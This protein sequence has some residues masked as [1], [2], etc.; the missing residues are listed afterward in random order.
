MPS[1]DSL[2]AMALARKN[3]LEVFGE[4]RAR[5]DARTRANARVPRNLSKRLPTFTM[6]VVA[7]VGYG[8]SECSSSIALLGQTISQLR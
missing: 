3:R 1:I 2:C 8:Q 6:S 4:T 7:D 5:P